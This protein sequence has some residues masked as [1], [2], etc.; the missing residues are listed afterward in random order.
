M[1]MCVA[2]RQMQPKNSLVRVVR[3]TDD[4]IIIDRT[5]KANGRGAYLCP[6]LDCLNKA[7]K[8]RALERALEKSIS[9]EV[10][11]LLKEEFMNEPKAE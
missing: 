8:I 3:G 4:K 2:C 7:V 1:R 11:E 5:G 10:I 9:P 6:K